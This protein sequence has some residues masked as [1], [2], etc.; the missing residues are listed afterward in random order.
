MISRDHEKTGTVQPNGISPFAK[1]L[2][3]VPVVFCFHTSSKTELFL[4]QLVSSPL[5]SVRLQLFSKKLSD[6]I[7]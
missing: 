7:E 1:R 6:A 4:K 5:G 2:C 3:V